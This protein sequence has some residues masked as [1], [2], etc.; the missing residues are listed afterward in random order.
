MRK[1]YILETLR[2]ED[3]EP[4]KIDASKQQIGAFYM[5]PEANNTRSN[6]PEKKSDKKDKSSENL[7]TFFAMVF[8]YYMGVT[9]ICWNCGQ[10]YK[11]DKGKNGY[12]CPIC[13]HFWKVTHCHN[14]HL[15]VKHWDNINNYHIIR[16]V[17]PI[18]NKTS[19][20]EKIERKEAKCPI[21]NAGWC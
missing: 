8:E 10:K 4:D 13:T 17:K 5:V 3:Y 20:K 11:Y 12:Y 6:S 19:T 1:I 21:C 9:N 14:K 15:L 7:K 18:D 2:K 16:E